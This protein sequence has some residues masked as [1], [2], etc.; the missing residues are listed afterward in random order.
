ML[1]F[2]TNITTM[3]K[4]NA[5]TLSKLKVL[6]S[7]WTVFYQKTHTYHWDLTGEN[8]LSF[9]KYLETLY[10][11]SV[12]HTDYIAERLRQLGEKTALTLNSAS[13]DSM[14]VD[15]NAA[16]SVNGIAEDLIAGIARLTSLQ[17]EIYTEADEQKDYVT[18][19]LMIQLSKWC[20]FNS[21]F[22]TSMVGENSNT[23]E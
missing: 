1:T 16:D 8:F 23:N 2:G 19:D 20:E 18:A 11:E 9:H 6:L 21:W 12:K 17:A 22:L 4:I 3:A 15:E 13:S 14:V 10:D 7:S 5:E